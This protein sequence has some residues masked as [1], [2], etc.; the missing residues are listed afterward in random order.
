MSRDPHKRKPVVI[1]MPTEVQAMP[2]HVVALVWIDE[3]HSIGLRFVSVDHLMRF[4]TELMDKAAVVWPSNAWV[5]EYL[6]GKE[7]PG[8]PHPALGA[9]G[10]APPRL[11]P[12]KEDPNTPGS[13][14][15]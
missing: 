3:Q 5:R 6:A 1:P 2:D 8:D 13:L 11:P 12:L 10:G 4:I 15:N 14:Y 7:P 9:G